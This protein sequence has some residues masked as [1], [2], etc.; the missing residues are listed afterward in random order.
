MT[1]NLFIRNF[2]K[3]GV[4]LSLLWDEDCKQFNVKNV[5]RGS[6]RVKP[7]FDIKPKEYL[8]K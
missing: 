7:D 5:N 8:R 6:K 4:T 2:P 1:A 3:S